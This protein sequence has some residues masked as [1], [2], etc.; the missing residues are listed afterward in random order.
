MHVAA[1]AQNT[2]SFDSSQWLNPSYESSYT[3]RIVP[4]K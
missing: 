2:D 3:W 4:I 1:S